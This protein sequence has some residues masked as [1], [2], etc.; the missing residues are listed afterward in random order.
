LPGLD[1]QPLT[2]RYPCPATIP[3]PEPRSRATDVLDR[4]DPTFKR[5][6]IVDIIENSDWAE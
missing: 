3:W 1:H 2:R 4:F 6:N 5:D